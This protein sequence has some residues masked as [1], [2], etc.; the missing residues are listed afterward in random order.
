MHNS[1]VSKIILSIF[2]VPLGTFSLTT[3]KSK[4][5][6]FLKVYSDYHLYEVVVVL[7]LVH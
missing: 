7:F 4:S 6:K 5:K 3:Q 1:M 2:C